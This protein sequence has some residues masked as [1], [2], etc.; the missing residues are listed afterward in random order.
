MCVLTSLVRGLIGIMG[1]S[2]CCEKV[3]LRR[4]RWTAVEDQKLK[5]YVLANGE[6]FWKSLP[7]NAGDFFF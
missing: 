7:K 4:G 5:N 1:R 3:G 2:P 6:G